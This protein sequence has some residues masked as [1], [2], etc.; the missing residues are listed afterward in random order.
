MM[1]ATS[2]KVSHS[3]EVQREVVSGVVH[4][5]YEPRVNR[6]QEREGERRA[7]PSRLGAS[8]HGDS[9]KGE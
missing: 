5:I 9:D 1:M 4:G 2:T 3:A 7:H 6:R 8:S